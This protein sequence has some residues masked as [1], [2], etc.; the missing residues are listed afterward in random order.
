MTG[1]SRLRFNLYYWGDAY[2]SMYWDR[3][4]LRLPS[5]MEPD[6]RELSTGMHRC[7]LRRGR[8]LPNV[9]KVAIQVT[10]SG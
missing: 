7:H 6:S 1:S 3:G 8:V 9:A 10:T 5:G 2:G 4:V